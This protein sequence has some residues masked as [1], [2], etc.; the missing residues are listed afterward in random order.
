MERYRDWD[1][2]SGIVAYEIGGDYIIVEFRS[3]KHR[4]YTYTHTSTGSA[5]VENMK[6]LARRGDGLNEFIVEHKVR[7]SSRK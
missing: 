2:D 5:N 1:N 3:G 7:Y 4:V 6:T